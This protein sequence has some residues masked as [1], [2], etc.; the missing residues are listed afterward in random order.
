M[1]IGGKM[2]PV[3]KVKEEYGKAKKKFAVDPST[4]EIVDAKKA[5][6]TWVSGTVVQQN[7]GQAIVQ[8]DKGMISIV[9][10]PESATPTGA[11]GEW[12]VRQRSSRV[13][14]RLAG[15]ERISMDAFDDV[16]LTASEFIQALN[17][18]R[19]MGVAIK[20]APNRIDD[21]SGEL[22]RMPSQWERKKIEVNKR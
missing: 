15:G 13:N 18:G 12:M 17:A 4:R 21:T 20:P 6:A 5:E 3:S 7:A 14:E 10:R 16:T 8:T 19:G 11:A 22:N 1:G 9:F 2:Y